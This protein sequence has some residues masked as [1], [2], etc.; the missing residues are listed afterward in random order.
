MNYRFNVLPKIELCRK[1]RW[2][3]N[4]GGLKHVKT[5]GCEMEGPLYMLYTCV[6]AQLQ[7]KKIMLHIIS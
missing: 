5:N 4:Q 7:S 3:Y 6:K 2:S 1:N